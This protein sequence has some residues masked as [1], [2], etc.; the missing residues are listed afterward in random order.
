ISQLKSVV[1][2]RGDVIRKLKET[3]RKTQHQDEQSFMEG[4][5]PHFKPG[6]QVKLPTCH[7]DKKIE[8]LEKK[9]VQFESLLNKQQEEINKWKKRAYRLRESK[10]E[11]PHSP[12]TPTKRP[13]LLAESDVYSPKK[14]ILDSPKSKFFDLHSDTE[15]MSI[16]CPKQFFDNSSLGTMPDAGPSSAVSSADTHPESWWHVPSAS[17][18]KTD[19]NLDANGCPTQ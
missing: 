19:L 8:D 14:S 11:A 13:L 9:T 1:E 3:L 18:V 17:P 2:H 12:R 6:A 4:E 15:T 16:K 10:K 7:K 5:D